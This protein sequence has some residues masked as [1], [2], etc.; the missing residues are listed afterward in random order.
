MIMNPGKVFVL[1]APS[2]AGKTTVLKR[3]MANVEG[4]AFSVSHC[5]RSPREGE[6]N[7]VDYYFVDRQEFITMKDQGHFLEYADVHGNFYG[8]SRSAVKEKTDKGVDVILDIDVQGARI[9]RDSMGLDATYIF[10]VP[11]SLNEL[12]NR[13]RGRG[14]DSGE[15][16]VTRLANAKKEID[17]VTEYEYLIVNEKIDE[18]VRMFEAI[19]LAERSKGRRLTCGKA[20]P[21][22][23]TSL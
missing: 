17:A 2:G 16:I 20:I 3:V 7:G 4:L 6:I 18:A 5:T 15:T 19:I 10:L 1:S 9:I 23:G 8:T 14:Q 21:D 11:P 22:F 13:L 12:E